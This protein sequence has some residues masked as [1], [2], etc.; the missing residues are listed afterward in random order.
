MPRGLPKLARQDYGRLDL[1]IAIRRLHVPPIV[2]QGVLEQHAV[3]KPEREARALVS[4][5]EQAH[6]LAYLAMVA[7]LS[8]L[9]HMLPC[10]KLFFAA[11]C[12]AVDAGEHFVVL[13]SLPIRS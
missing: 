9:N 10:V 5:H 8:L 12:D 7:L 2:H 1:V 11:K 6:F 13:V 3:G 4:H